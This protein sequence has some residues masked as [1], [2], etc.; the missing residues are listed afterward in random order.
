[1]VVDAELAQGVGYDGDEE[2]SREDGLKCQG[3]EGM[4]LL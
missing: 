2:E 1:M 3:L 4:V